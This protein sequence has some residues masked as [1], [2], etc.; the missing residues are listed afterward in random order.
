M[1]PNQ[2]RIHGNGEPSPSAIPGKP[3]SDLAPPAILRAAANCFPKCSA[4]ERDVKG[5]NTNPNIACQETEYAKQR[6]LTV[7]PWPEKSGDEMHSKC[8]CLN[9]LSSIYSTINSDAVIWLQNDDH[10]HEVTSVL[11]DTGALGGNYGS[12]DFGELLEREGYGVMVTGPNCS[13]KGYELVCT[14]FGDCKVV[15]KVFRGVKL[16]IQVNE[17]TTLNFITTIKITDIKAYEL[18]IGRHLLKEMQK[19]MTPVGCGYCALPFPSA[20]VTERLLDAKPPH[21]AAEPLLAT[22][23][24]KWE[25]FQNYSEEAEED[26]VLEAAE[27]F[28]KLTV[29]PV[30]QATGAP[31][32]LVRIHGTPT[33]QRQLKELVESYKDI[34][35]T[36]LGSQPA[37]LDGMDLNVDLSRWQQPGNRTPPRPQTLP[38]Q[39]EIRR[40][41]RAMEDAKIIVKS[42][43]AHYSHVLLTPK[44]NGKWRFC[45][46]YRKLNEV[47][48]SIGWPIPNIRSTL[49]RI[50]AKRA[51][52]FGVMDLTSGYHQI[53][54]SK[55]A[56]QFT[57]FTTY[58][59]IYEFLRVPFGLKGSPAFF[60]RLMSTVVLN[61][62]M[63]VICEVYLDDVL[64]FGQTEDEYI[65]NLR[66]VFD[67]FRLYNLKVNPEKTSLGLEEVQYVGHIINH[68]GMSFSKEKR[69][70]V[71]KVECPRTMRQLKSFLGLANYFREHV[72]NYAEITQVLQ[73]L[74]SAYQPA[75]PVKWTPPALA[76]FNQIK[77]AIQQAPMLYF[78]DEVSPIVL[79]TDASD[80]G[81]GG[82]LFQVVTQPDGSTKEAPI[83]FVSKSLTA[84]Q[85]ANWGVGEKECYAIWYAL[86]KL[87]HLIRD[88]KFI[89][90]T[91]HRNLT[92]LNQNV[93]NRVRRWK[94][95]IQE[96][97]FQIEY[98]KGPDNVIAD[99]LSRQQPPEHSILANLVTVDKI[100]DKYYA[101]I[102][103]VHNS[104][105]GHHGVDRTMKHLIRKDLHWPGM[106]KHVRWFIKECPMC[107]LMSQIKVPIQIVRYTLASYRVM[108]RI[109][110]DT[111]GPLPPDE[112][113]NQ[114]ILVIID[115]F[116]RWIQLYSTKSVTA[117]EAAIHLLTWVSN[118]S[119]PCEIK[120]DG[121]S[122]F[123][124]ELIDNL[125][126]LIGTE[127]Q[128]T[129]AYS[130]EENG[131]VERA[132]KSVMLHLRNIVTDR[133]VINQW[134]DYLPL[135]QRIMNATPHTSTG[136]APFQLLY[137]NSIHLD[138]GF[139]FRVP[140]Q[141][142]NEE[143]LSEYMVRMIQQQ[144]TVLQVAQETQYKEDTRNRSR[145]QREDILA[146]TQ[147]PEAPAT[148]KPITEFAEGAYVL[149]EYANTGLGKKP[150]NKLSPTLEGPFQVIGHAG[151]EY[152]L[153]NLTTGRSVKRHILRLRPFY[154]DPDKT[155]PREIANKDKQMWT[156]EKIIAHR[157]KA[158]ARRDL[159]F[160]VRWLGFPPEE[161]TWEPYNELRHNAHLHT[162]L[163]NNGMKALIPQTH[164]KPDPMV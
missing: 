145:R 12:K 11:M 6:K 24:E 57:A 50:G 44:P 58:F 14:P 146:R 77:G 64:V 106:R 113:G 39:E 117:A 7:L 17:T 52:W 147:D 76:A 142:I 130:H 135:V 80:Y 86:N 107:Q 74:T 38:K 35:D 34:F 110:V 114:Y 5:W 123:V 20:Q 96:Y 111:I 70:E 51:R 127:H 138:E 149:A 108:E 128:L 61:E 159:K 27:W 47:T 124:N 16:L 129:I 30:S 104:L 8:S 69:D 56:Q 137:A 119:A 82:Y 1:H 125:L 103:R 25:V 28:E 98:I 158:S 132:N 19:Q 131:I 75:R 97:D 54:M 148:H 99:A 92:F 136:T 102:G 73:T 13:N 164:S 37:H 40:Q 42:H 156:I 84:S 118:Y 144:T 150:P 160:Q 55:Q 10:K 4:R 65:S 141:N 45:I 133:R 120:S 81:I 100:P 62:L 116:S 22:M 154:Y 139:V 49:Q 43:A 121:G 68:E 126:L 161:D 36:V 163:A 152:L 162:Y 88:T 143:S 115:C 90:R 153:R 31:Y 63:Y 71:F 21:T 15:S 112:K 26:D 79:C 94:M 95:A 66:Q 91:D 23:L 67:K 32:E 48:S 41:V 140:L 157:G 109:N 59:G 2:S 33:L 3:P 83:A 72:R 101:E 46:D 78:L 122:Q 60:Q 155:D 53:K 9:N 89:L 105:V 93:D 18:I 29:Q 151:A 85:A 134:A 87:Q